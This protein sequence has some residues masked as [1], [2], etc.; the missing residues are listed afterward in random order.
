MAAEITQ[1]GLR[2]MLEAA[3]SEETVV[4]DAVYLALVSDTGVK[5]SDTISDLTEVATPGAEGYTRQTV[6]TSDVGFTTSDAGSN[7]W[8]VTTTTET[9][10][11]AGTWKVAGAVVMV[12]SDYGTAGVK[13]IGSTDLG[14]ARTLTSGDSLQVAMQLKLAN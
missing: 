7:D 9:F 10:T 12:T 8:M 13:L 3:F 14:T 11:C 2:Y 1:Q 5:E 6:A 4:S